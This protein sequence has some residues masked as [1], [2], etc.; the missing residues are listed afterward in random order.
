M[1]PPT[2]SQKRARREENGDEEYGPNEGSNYKIRSQCES[3]CLFAQVSTPHGDASS[4]LAANYCRENNILLDRM[5]AQREEN[6]V[7]A[8]Q[9]VDD[10]N[11]VF[12]DVLCDDTTEE[13][14]KEYLEPMIQ[15]ATIFIVVK[16]DANEW[17]GSHFHIFHVCLKLNGDR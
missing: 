1:D 2:S 8:L 11:I 12:H 16:H 13:T 4:L 3:Q 10:H 15:D 9:M 7:M 5:V 6:W 14:L 17:I